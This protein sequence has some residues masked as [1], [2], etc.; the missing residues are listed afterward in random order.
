MIASSLIQ[1]SAASNVPRVKHITPEEVANLAT[2]LAS[3]ASLA[4][5][6]LRYGR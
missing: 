2:F 5:T 6:T 3:D 4:S 1:L